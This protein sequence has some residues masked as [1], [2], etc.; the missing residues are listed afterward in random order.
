MLETFSDKFCKF[1]RG[2]KFESLSVLTSEFHL[3]S[4]RVR[5]WVFESFRERLG[6]FECVWEFLSFQQ[7]EIFWE[8]SSFWE[9]FRV[10]ESFQECLRVRAVGVGRWFFPAHLMNLFRLLS[11]IRSST[12]S[13]RKGVRA[14]IRL[15][16]PHV[17]SHGVP[18]AQMRT[19]PQII[20]DQVCS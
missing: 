6:V 14:E 13:V 9:L 17:R 12:F 3:E 1:C 10:F 7:F 2:C 8:L 20:H 18:S 5:E 11:I 4:L 19:L 15:G 16:P